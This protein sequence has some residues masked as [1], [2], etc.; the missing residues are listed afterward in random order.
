[1][2]WNETKIQR[3]RL[4]SLL[5]DFVDLEM[6][7]VHK[8]IPVVIP[9][10]NNKKIKIKSGLKYY[11]LDIDNKKSLSYLTDIRLDTLIK[12]HLKINV[13]NPKLYKR[14]SKKRDIRERTFDH[15]GYYDNI[16]RNKETERLKIVRK[17]DYSFS[18]LLYLPPAQRDDYYDMGIK[19]SLF[20][21]LKERNPILHAEY[22]KILSEH[23]IN[24]NSPLRRPKINME[25]KIEE[26]RNILSSCKRRK[27]KYDILIQL[28]WYC[29]SRESYIEI[30]NTLKKFE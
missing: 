16:K 5:N 6:I 20:T 18:P 23:G 17:M 1:M 21:R 27:S 3:N 14:H 4:R 11:I 2:L 8:F 24:L 25:S 7:I 13:I 12:D 29:S 28:S 15:Y 22:M 10:I 9:S 30:W 19:Y 26:I